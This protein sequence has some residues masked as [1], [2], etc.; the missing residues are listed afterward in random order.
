MALAEL[1]SHFRD[2]SA[3]VADFQN[4][5]GQLKQQTIVPGAGMILI[6]NANKE[7]EG[8]GACAATCANKERRSYVSL[9]MAVAELPSHFGDLGACVAA[10]QKRFEQFLRTH[11]RAAS[12]ILSVFP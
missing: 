9:G 2:V 8:S 4:S 1:P 10:L 6:T 3:C 11:L 12:P 7:F 5:F